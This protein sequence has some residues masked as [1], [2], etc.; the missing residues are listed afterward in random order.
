MAVTLALAGSGLLAQGMPST[1]AVP[2]LPAHVLLVGDSTMATRTGY[3]DALCGRLRP[4]VHCT[5][6]ARG[7]RSSKSYRAEGLWDGVLAQ[8]KAG[9]GAGWPVWVLIQF[10][11]NDQPGKPGR[12]TDLATEFPLNLTHYVAQARDLGAHVV[13]VS[14]LTR[15]SFHDGQLV[16]DLRPWALAVEAVAQRTGVP[17]LDLHQRSVQ[18]VQAMGPA[19]ADGLA[20][21]PPPESWPPN[22]APASPASAPGVPRPLG[23]GFDHT[24]LGSRGAAVFA[25]LLAELARQQ[26]PAWA[27]LLRDQ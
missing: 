19:A 7:G 10:G 6:L 21:A 18:V 22:A 11:H 16:A 12:S 15:R 24:H 23:H 4:P 20:M 14:P 2:A 26:I 13:L 25:D 27:D 3:G 1:Q 17:F 5:N 9:T 8:V